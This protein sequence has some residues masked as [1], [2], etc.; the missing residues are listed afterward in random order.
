ML[1]RRVH[2]LRYEL[3][4]CNGYKSMEKEVVDLRFAEKAGGG[5][6]CAWFERRVK[7]SERMGKKRRSAEGN[8]V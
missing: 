3:E 1:S 2:E 5:N 7:Y 4:E 6:R 8:A